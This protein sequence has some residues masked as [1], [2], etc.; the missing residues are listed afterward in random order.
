MNRKV[1]LVLLLVLGVMK[2]FSPSQWCRLFIA[3]NIQNEKPQITILTVG[4]WVLLCTEFC[5]LCC[6]IKM[7]LLYLL[8]NLFLVFLLQVRISKLQLQLEITYD[9]F[10]VWYL[11]DKTTRNM[12]R[13]EIV[14][15]ISQTLIVFLKSPPQPLV[16]FQ[17]L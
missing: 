5:T 6:I 1:M 9:L 4:C 15:K 13:N 7:N 11:L 16:T 3:E 2:I 17:P 12:L 14:F 10:T 8:S